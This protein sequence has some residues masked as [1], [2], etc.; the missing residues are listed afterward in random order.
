MRSLL[1][2][3]AFT[4]ILAA[5]SLSQNPPSTTEPEFEGIFNGLDPIS[6]KL[7]PLERRTAQ[8]VIKKGKLAGAKQFLEIPE[9][10]SKVR[11][12]SSVVPTIVVR[13]ADTKKDPYAHLRFYLMEVNKKT[14]SLPTHNVSSW[15]GTITE[16]FQKFKI[17]FE[18]KLHGSSSF[19][20]SPATILKPGDYCLFTEGSNEWFCFGVD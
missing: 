18:A 15:D 9:A 12:A 17:S 6:D 10:R 19:A 5:P 16:E 2:I 7:I 13:V 1:S 14:R 8:L 4:L 3:L 20:I 11:F